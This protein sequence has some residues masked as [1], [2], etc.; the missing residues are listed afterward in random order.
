M[1]IQELFDRNEPINMI[2]VGE[3]LRKKFS[4]D[5][6]LEKYLIETINPSLTD[7][8]TSYFISQAHAESVYRALVDK[9]LFRTLANIARE[10]HEN[11]HTQTSP[12][13]QIAHKGI[14]KLQNILLQGAGETGKSIGELSRELYTTIEQIA[15]RRREGQ[16]LVG[17]SSGFPALDRITGGWRPSDYI[18]I[19]ARTSMG[20]TAF[21]L[22][23]AMH[24][25]SVEQKP[26]MIFSLEMS[27]VQLAMRILSSYSG[28]PLQKIRNAQLEEP[29]LKALETAVEQLQDLPIWI[30]DTGDLSLYDLRARATLARTQHNIELFMVD[31]LQQVRVTLERR[32]TTREQEVSMVSRTLKALA[33]ELESPFIVISQLSRQTEQRLDNKP[34]LSDLRESGA[35]EQDAD[36]VIFL[37]RPE[38]YGD[39]KS[40]FEGYTEVE[41]A[42]NRN[43]P[44]GTTILKFNRQLVR[45]ENPSPEELSAAGVTD[46]DTQNSQHE[47]T[48]IQSRHSIPSTPNNDNSLTTHEDEEP[49][50]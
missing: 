43:G 2:T 8:A 49:P 7:I 6:T 47:T 27:A 5:S 37:Y 21:M 31:Y 42:K 11:A 44:T 48:T 12:P 28:V 13:Y 41:V 39:T 23:I 34:R 20:K 24:V 45:F 38:Y 36:I 19:A 1:A 50:F 35:I 32:H 33:K 15:T 26:V 25:A 30:D 4:E 18:I 10:L 16:I 9:F 29:E 17:I 3:L 40:A 14:E 46:N 22:S